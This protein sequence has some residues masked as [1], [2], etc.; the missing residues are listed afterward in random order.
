MYHTPLHAA[1][2]YSRHKREAEERVLDR[3][4]EAVFLLTTWLYNLPGHGLPIRGNLVI[5]LLRA[6]LP[7]KVPPSWVALYSAWDRVPSGV[8]EPVAAWSTGWILLAFRRQA[9]SGQS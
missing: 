3:L 7:K 2:I 5:N 4:H 9:A 8:S 1:N 6:A